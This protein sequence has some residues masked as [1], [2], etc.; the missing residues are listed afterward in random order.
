ML[1][2]TDI[3]LTFNDDIAIVIGEV[4]SVIAYDI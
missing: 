4:G 2:I 1:A 3:Y